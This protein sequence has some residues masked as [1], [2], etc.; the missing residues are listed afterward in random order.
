VS[1]NL[2]SPEA[3]KGILTEAGVTSMRVEPVLEEAGEGR[4]SLAYLAIAAGAAS[5]LLAL[6]TGATPKQGQ[7]P[8]RSAADARGPPAARAGSAAQGGMLPVPAVLQNMS[9]RAGRVEV[10]LSAGRARVSL[11]PRATTDVYAYNG[12]VPGPTLELMEGDEVIVRFR[13]DLPEATTVHWH[14]LHIPFEA[15]GSP[16]HPVA[17]GETHEYRFTIPRGSAGTYWYHPHPHHRTAWQV[18]MGLYGAIV[19]RARGDPLPDVTEKLL[20]LSDNRFLPDGSLD[21]PDPAT[22]QGELDALNGREGNVL[23][24]NGVVMP[25]VSIR[26]GEVQRWRVINAAGARIYRLAIPGHTF[27]HVGSD[28]GLFERPVEVQEILLANGERAELLVRGTATPGA[29]TV[30]QTLPYD[31]YMARTRPADWD[32]PLD[33]LMLQYAG[34]AEET[35][36]SIPGKLRTVEPLDTAAVSA[37][38]LMLMSQGRINGR[39]LD[40]GRIDVEAEL[41]ATEIWE[42]E[43]LVGMDHPFHLHGFQFQVLERNGEPEPFPTWKDTVNVPKRG[44]VR[45]IVRYAD[46]RGKWM[47]HCHIL[48]HEDQGMMGVLLVH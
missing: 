15:D 2:I 41:G 16:F 7:G 18:G 14:G 27:L 17:P 8:P 24:V 26:P 48:D 35:S 36:F 19:V 30:L 44:A 25:T 33:L 3:G 47:F 5:L 13:N 42:V 37:T 6:L 11:L 9:S 31:R 43:N 22:P 45:F 12:T 29:H 32:Q 38:R 34:E 1:L 28:G 39:T 20:I 46:H 4:K 10:E 40:L 23:F 21:F